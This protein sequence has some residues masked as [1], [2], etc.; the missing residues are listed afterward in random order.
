LYRRDD[1]PSPTKRGG[2]EN[3]K[4]PV[5]RTCSGLGGSQTGMGVVEREEYFE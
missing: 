1:G 4:T 5:Q 3:G 2:K